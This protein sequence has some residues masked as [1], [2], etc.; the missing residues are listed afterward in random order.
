MS[1]QNPGSAMRPVFDLIIRNGTVI[2]GTK[3]PRYDAD[4]GILDG[5][6]AEVGDL[7]M[8]KARDIMDAA[9]KIVAPGFIDSHTHDD[10]AL[11]VQPDMDFKISQGVTTVIT[12]NCGISLAP[13]GE[14]VPVPA[15]LNL[16]A[17]DSDRPRH[18]SFAAYI[19]ALRERPAA[20]NAAALVGHSTLRVMAMKDLG[21]AADESEIATM[22]RLLGEALDAGAIGM[23]TGTYYPPAAAASTEEII[24]VGRPLTGAGGL[25]VTH[26]RD[27]ADHC[28]D[29]L[30][31]TFRI[32][33]ELD[34]RVVVSHHKLQRQENFGKS[35]I[36]LPRI[37]EAMRCQCVALDC[38]PYNASSTML[39]TDPK[40]LTGRIMIA[41][42]GS[43]PE[44]AGRDLDQIAAEWQVS[45]VE[46]AQ[47]LQPASA[48]YF[49]MDEAD[50]RKILAFEDTMIGSDGIPQG[51]KPHPRLWGTFPRVIGHYCRELALFP[52]P[53]AI[54]KMTSLPAA[55]FGLADRGVIREGAFA[56]LVLFDFRQIRDM[57]TFERPTEPSRGIDAVIVNGRVAWQGGAVAERAGVLLK[58]ASTLH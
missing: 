57:A 49:T 50:V 27:E 32:G 52:L 10:H 25:Y 2:D 29:S 4:V 37:R 53:E 6:I 1:E 3:R 28:L 19:D 46:A 14:G 47:R 5:R 34:I 30:E 16:L 42:S 22:R 9:G 58:G 41:F 24:E 20:I 33:R 23:S 21:K 43:H 31:E 39:H 35:A 13:L 44:Y 38:Y 15:P 36:T 56:D 17:G 51:E 7:S 8:A 54:R 45:I 55:N 12:G 11:L 40:R 26:M 48:I 18:H